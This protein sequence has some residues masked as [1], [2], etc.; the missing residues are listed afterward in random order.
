[1]TSIL[2]HALI[3]NFHPVHVGFDLRPRK[4][5]ASRYKDD[6][7]LGAMVDVIITDPFRYD[8]TPHI[9]TLTALDTILR[10]NPS[11]IITLSHQTRLTALLHTP[12]PTRI[13]TPHLC[14]QAHSF[15]VYDMTLSCPS[16][17]LAFTCNI[18]LKMTINHTYISLETHSS[19]IL[20]G[21]VRSPLQ[22]LHADKP[23]QR[24]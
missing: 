11:V 9:V 6:S 8:S 22:P 19:L 18:V 16:H 15:T 20:R 2:Y 24:L 14:K 17:R 21:I 1:M 12:H 7:T 23:S 10:S 3:H 4:K 5:L 13:R